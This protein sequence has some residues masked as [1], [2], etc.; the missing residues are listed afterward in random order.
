MQ[1][2][3]P[4]LDHLEIF[5][6]A[7]QDV[8]SKITPIYPVRYGYASA[9]GEDFRPD[10][11]PP[12]LNDF[13]PHKYQ[14]NAKR[15]SLNERAKDD[16]NVD[17]SLSGYLPGLCREGW[18]YIREEAFY[19]EDFNE[20]D[21]YFSKD[22]KV[23]N[24]ASREQDFIH[25]FRCMRF[26]IG[27]MP[28]Q[29]WFVKYEFGENWSVLKP[30]KIYPYL[31]VREDR[32]RISIAYSEHVWS[33]KVLRGLHRDAK[34]R[35]RCMQQMSLCNYHE[36]QD[37]GW[38]TRSIVMA[39]RKNFDYLR[40]FYDRSGLLSDR[41]AAKMQ[42]PEVSEEHPDPLDPK[43]VDTVLSNI[44][45][46][47]SDE[48]YDM[49]YAPNMADAYLSGEM[50]RG[51]IVALYDP[52]GVQKEI[53]R[54]HARLGI[55]KQ[56]YLSAHRH[57]H[58]IGT[59]ID[60]ILSS[61]SLDQDDIEHIRDDALNQQAFHHYWGKIKDT[62]TKLDQT[63]ERLI[64]D[65]SFFLNNEQWRYWPFN[66]TLLGKGSESVGLL[67]NH[68]I[69]FFDHDPDRPEDAEP[70]VIK[71][72]MAT[73]EMFDGIASSTAGEEA[74]EIALS[75]TTVKGEELTVS[76]L[77]KT[78]L[79][80]ALHPQELLDISS[81]TAQLLDRFLYGFATIL[82]KGSALGDLVRKVPGALSRSPQFIKTKLNMNAIRRI[83]DGFLPAI[84]RIFGV[85]PGAEANVELTSEQLESTWL[86]AKREKAAGKKNGRFKNNRM[87]IWLQ[88]TAKKVIRVKPL[89]FA[90]KSIVPQG[91]FGLVGKHRI[92]ISV[93][94]SLTGLSLLFNLQAMYSFAVESKFDQADPQ[95]QEKDGAHEFIA[96]CSI[97]SAIIADGLS[98]R[99]VAIEISAFTAKSSGD[100]ALAATAVSADKL[101]RLITSHVLI[102]ANVVG[103]A[104]SAWDALLAFEDGNIVEG[105]GHSSLAMSNIIFIAGSV[106]SF[107]LLVFGVAAVLFIVGAILITLFATPP[108]EKL[109][110]NGFWGKSRRYPYWNSSRM[111]GSYKLMLMKARQIDRDETLQQAYISE[112]QEYSNLFFRPQLIVHS[113][114]IVDPDSPFDF[115]PNIKPEFTNSG[116]HELTFKLPNFREGLSQIYGDLYSDPGLRRIDKNATRLLRQK[117]SE[118]L[119]G[120]P[121]RDTKQLDTFSV[122]N[123]V[124]TLKVLLNLDI[125]SEINFLWSYAPRPDVLV[126][127]RLDISEE[128]SS[129]QWKGGLHNNDNVF[130]DM[131]KLF[132]D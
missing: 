85:E 69:Y 16:L 81:V 91:S 93:G 80:L 4:D 78:T 39:T 68:L 45:A 113:R 13:F 12:P 53:A 48:S 34:K 26:A 7:L 114:R 57:P 46:L 98:A 88:E 30:E 8:S 58:T 31:F 2:I 22:Q 25:I 59:F 92:S 15:H 127:M 36:K 106:K 107:G 19:H 117:M 28:V 56:H 109:V 132:S 102:I 123:G 52:V 32:K 49:L 9:I 120:K 130:V 116:E 41:V 103:A 66:M 95:K 11:P 119:S 44:H 51:Y 21:E 40:G 104:K 99:A 122:K 97:M 131:D 79:N 75:K 126:P 70:E 71:L 112:L 20:V 33:P 115:G 110:K 42:Y 94:S 100:A 29:E 74:L 17:P 3:E 129:Q 96:F 124:I 6:D 27:D 83:R 23:L 67:H 108:L 62:I 5:E 125:H 86:E 82:A 18:I 38:N 77:L 72:L 1:V 111:G 76:L 43:S 24:E 73:I 118:V 121:A 64:G 89:L 14:P 101:N 84:Y 35:A 54:A 63:Q 55:L 47:A 10:A 61:D 128:S 37:A 90:A 105:F 60:Q 87:I 50:P 65:F